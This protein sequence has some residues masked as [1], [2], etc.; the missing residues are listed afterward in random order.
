MFTLIL[1][2]TI[3]AIFLYWWNTKDKTKLN[4]QIADLRGQ[5]LKEAA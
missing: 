3:V 5:L 1:L 4:Q 2:I